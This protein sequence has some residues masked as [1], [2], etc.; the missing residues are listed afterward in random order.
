MF[1]ERK[2]ESSTVVFWN[3]EDGTYEQSI[4]YSYITANAKLVN[5]TLD[6]PKTVNATEL[7][8]SLFAFVHISY[9]LLSPG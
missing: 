9:V 8:V 7:Q 4:N 1:E 6:G 5:L 2:T 3:V